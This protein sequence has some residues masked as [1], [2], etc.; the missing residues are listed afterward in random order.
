MSEPSNNKTLAFVISLCFVC[1]LVLSFLATALKKPQEEAKEL[2]MSKQLLIAAHI[3]NFDEEFISTGKK[4]SR[5]EILDLF[6][7][8][9]TPMLVNSKGELYTFETAGIDYKTYV[10]E[11]AKYGY[12]KLPNKLIYVI[13][14]GEKRDGYVI[15]ING[16][17]L[18]DAIYGYLGIAANADT[19][20]G[21]SWYDQ[22]E[23]PGLG[24][25]ISLPDWQEQFYHKEIFRPS[26][27]GETNFER[28]P[29]G[30][31]VVKTTVKETYGE[32]PAGR[33][34]VDGIAGSTFTVTGVNEA[35]RNVLAEYRPFL[36]K[37]HHEAS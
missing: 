30:I 13:H 18:W 8:R 24:G 27:D 33:S 9:I 31:Q 19:V 12:S 3:L 1:A 6:E 10:R 26:P 2:Y 25:N 7:K 36:L 21:M 4:A 29:L 22:K 5:R 37:A 16:Y 14:T 32:R 11:N 20:I 23:T 15:P 28:A 34:A 17:G 35:F